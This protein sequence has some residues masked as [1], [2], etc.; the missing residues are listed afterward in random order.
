MGEL[1]E[2]DNCGKELARKQK[3]YCGRPCMN[4]HQARLRW[5]ARRLSHFPRR[6][7]RAADELEVA[8]LRRESGL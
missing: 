4:A 2:C 8:R 5:A 3:R 7:K 1:R 6:G